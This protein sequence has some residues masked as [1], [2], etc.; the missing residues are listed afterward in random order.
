MDPEEDGWPT[1]LEGFRG[2]LNYLAWEYLL[3]EAHLRKRI[4]P[5]DL[6]QDTLLEAQAHKARMDGAPPAQLRAWLQSVLA[7]NLQDQIRKFKRAKR[8]IRRD[9][10]NAFGRATIRLRLFAR[11]TA[12]SQRA[13]REEEILKVLDA[14]ERLSEPAKTIVRL[15]YLKERPFPEIANHVGLTEG[16]AATHLHRALGKLREMMEAGR[17]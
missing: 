1:K 7:H 17:E 14:V 2:L 12:P 8:D 13:A 16:A 10:T 3:D 15:R 4:D 5:A 9:I 6:V 11:Q